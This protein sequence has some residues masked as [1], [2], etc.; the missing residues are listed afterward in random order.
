MLP[1]YLG[2]SLENIGIEAQDVVILEGE[3]KYPIT[4]QYPL[5][6]YREVGID[7]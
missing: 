1:P 6:S 7:R 4:A 5:L 2:L 3:R